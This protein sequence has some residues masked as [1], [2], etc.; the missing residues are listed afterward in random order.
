[1]TLAEPGCKA[2]YSNDLR[3]RIIWQRFGMEVSL[4]QVAENLNI[5][6][7]TAYNIC[8]LFESTEN[9][10]NR[11]SMREH[12]RLFN[13]EQEL[14]IMG[15]LVDN[16]NLYL[17]EICQ[18]VYHM[19]NIE[20]SPS[21]ICRLIYRYGFTRKKIQ[22]IAQQRSTEHRAEF[23]AAVVMFSAEKFVWVDES[24][25]D[26]TDQIRKF[27]YALQEE[28]PVFHRLLY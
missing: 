17:H 9:V 4:R 8:K 18:K 24:G 5:S 10:D 21:T 22:Q 20:V 28:L 11:T 25:C 12:N 15:L 6:L 14:W 1:M 16:P 27:G 7:G 19:F 2:P 3:W 13:D 23:M 26:R